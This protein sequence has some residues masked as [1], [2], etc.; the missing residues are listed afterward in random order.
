MQESDT[1]WVL[2]ELARDKEVSSIVARGIWLAHEEWD[3]GTPGAMVQAQ[4]L[5]GHCAKQY[6]QGLLLGAVMFGDMKSY[7]K[8]HF[9]GETARFVEIVDWGYVGEMLLSAESYMK[10]CKEL[11]DA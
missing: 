7:V 6:V 3:P 10:V 9:V 4:R 5:V 2:R 8:E 1:V 11:E